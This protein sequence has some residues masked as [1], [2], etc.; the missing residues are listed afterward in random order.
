MVVRIQVLKHHAVG[1][2]IG[3]IVDRLALLVLDDLFLLGQHGVG[4]GVDEIAQLVGLGPDHLLQRVIGHGLQVV[5]DVETGRAV[6]PRA[7]DAGAHGIQ[8]AGPEV[9]RIEEEQVLE[10][11]GEAGPARLLARRSDPGGQHHR[12]HGVGAVNVEDHAQTVLQLVGLHGNQRLGRGRLG[13]RRFRDLLGR[14]R[15]D[16]S[17]RQNN[18]ADARQQ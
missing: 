5:G 1:V 9:F 6:G 13:D 7:A 15:A 8:A 4:D 12:D 16:S 2:A 18:A 10:Q 11:V 14:G 17:D 3:R